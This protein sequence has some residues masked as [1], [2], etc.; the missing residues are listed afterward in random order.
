MLIRFVYICITFL[1]IASAAHAQALTPF[2]DENAQYKV[3]VGDTLSNIFRRLKIYPIWTPNGSIEKTIKL[4]AHDPVLIK[5]RHKLEPDRVIS[6]PIKNG[7]TRFK[8]NKNGLLVLEPFRGDSYPHKKRKKRRQ[9]SSQKTNKIKNLNFEYDCALANSNNIYRNLGTIINWHQ[10]KI[11]NLNVQFKCNNKANKIQQ[12]REPA[13]YKEKDFKIKPWMMSFAPQTQSS[14][15]QLSG[16][17]KRKSFFFPSIGYNTVSYSEGTFNNS[18]TNAFVAFRYRQIIKKPYWHID[19]EIKYG[20][21]SLS[22]DYLNSEAQVL[23]IDLRAG[24]SIQ[25]FDEPWNFTLFA[26]AFYTQMLVKDDLYGYKGTFYPQIYPEVRRL[27]SSGDSL[28]LFF[29][30]MPTGKNFFDL[31]GN[32]ALT[33]GAQY[34]TD[35]LEKDLFFN[36]NYSTLEFESTS[37]INVEIN[38]TSLGIGAGF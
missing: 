17:N 1:F 9:I 13:L 6:L 37:N 24:R 4:N 26:G 5:D 14:S 7:D 28:N 21:L 19:S 3:K 16:Q 18:F 23:D 33:L 8:Y 25:L 30:Y 11:E 22:N 10:S 15:S 38:Q 34:N 35:F 36:V 32:A 12:V 20:A 2:Q 31:N 29:K 27:F